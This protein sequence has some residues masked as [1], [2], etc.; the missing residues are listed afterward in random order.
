MLLFTTNSVFSPRRRTDA[1]LPGVR[2][3]WSFPSY[4]ISHSF[5]AFVPSDSMAVIV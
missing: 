5:S 2:V 4:W 3:G 1:V